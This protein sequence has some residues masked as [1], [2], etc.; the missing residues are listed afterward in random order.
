MLYGGNMLQCMALPDVYLREHVCTCGAGGEGAF[1]HACNPSPV[2]G[3]YVC[4]GM[5]VSGVTWRRHNLLVAGG[6]LGVLASLSAAVMVGVSLLSPGQ[7]GVH[8]LMVRPFVVVRS[9]SVQS[10]Q[11]NFV[12]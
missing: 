3:V 6:Q 12:C 11:R 8:M 10:A 2:L 1:M 5:H 9:T 7:S 4:A